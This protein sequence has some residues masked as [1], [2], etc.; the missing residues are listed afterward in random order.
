MGSPLHYFSSRNSGKYCWHL[1][2]QQRN[3]KINQR[4]EKPKKKA[5][6]LW[7]LGKGKLGKMREA[8]QEYTVEESLCFFPSNLKGPYHRPAY[9]THLY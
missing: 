7:D 4:W 3:H 1:P 9:C 6:G 8:V 5:T 2:E